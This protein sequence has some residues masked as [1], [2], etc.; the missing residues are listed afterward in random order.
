MML[1]SARFAGAPRSRAFRDLLNHSS[2][3]AEVEALGKRD[4][5]VRFRGSA[6]QWQLFKPRTRQRS[7]FCFQNDLRFLVT[8]CDYHDRRKISGQARR[9]RGCSTR[10]SQALKRL[11]MRSPAQGLLQPISHTG[12]NL[13][14]FACKNFG[15]QRFAFRRLLRVCAALSSLSASAAP[16]RP[17]L[18]DRNLV[19][20]LSH[21]YTTA[22]ITL[23]QIMRVSLIAYTQIA[24]GGAEETDF[25]RLRYTRLLIVA[26]AR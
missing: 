6:G 14:Q 16:M 25:Y 26:G 12:R 19:S 20:A 1:S 21:G 13:Q 17:D 7:H 9:S 15:D 8:R 2:P 5:F 18:H 23:N 22:K 4:C 10:N 24:D 11:H 3:R